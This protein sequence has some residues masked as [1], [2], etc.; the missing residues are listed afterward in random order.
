MKNFPTPRWYWAT[1]G[2]GA[3]AALYELVLDHGTERGVIIMAAFGLMGID[4]V[5]RKD[6]EHKP[7]TKE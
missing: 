5:A 6:G 1:R 4:W 3:F 2:V 7:P